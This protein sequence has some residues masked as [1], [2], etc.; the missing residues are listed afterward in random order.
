MNKLIKTM[1]V[2]SA[3]LASGSALA[4]EE[5][6]TYW[7]DT[8]ESG[9]SKNAWTTPSLWV[10][11]E[12]KSPEKVFD[13]T[14]DYVVGIQ[15]TSQKAAYLRWRNNNDARNFAG[16]S[17]TI[18]DGGGLRLLAAGGSATDPVT[19]GSGG[20][21][22]DKGTLY[23]FSNGGTLYFGGLVTV[24]SG[25]AT[26]QAN[27]DSS[28]PAPTAYFYS[29]FAGEEDATIKFITSKTNYQVFVSGDFQNFKGKVQVTSNT[30]GSGV[31]YGTRL[32]MRSD[33]PGSLE[34]LVGSTLIGAAPGETI[35]VKNLSFANGSVFEIPFADDGSSSGAVTVT[36]DLKL[37]A[38]PQPLV[39]TGLVADKLVKTPICR[40]FFT[41]PLA[42]KLSL[43][44]FAITGIPEG[45]AETP[46]LEL[47]TNETAQTVSLVLKTD[48]LISQTVADKH[49]TY[50]PDTSA[51]GNPDSWDAPLSSA[52][53]YYSNLQLCSAYDSTRSET[54]DG[55]SLT[56]EGNTFIVGLRDFRIDDL[57]IVDA[58]SLVPANRPIG[59]SSSVIVHYGISG[60]ITVPEG[61]TLTLLPWCG[62][63][64]EFWINSEICGSGDILFPGRTGTD[65][66]T[67]L[68]ILAGPNTN[69]FGGIKVRQQATRTYPDASRHQ[70]FRFF[71]PRNLGG[72]LAELN[73][74][75][76]EIG[77]YTQVT[78]TNSV[79][80]TR[81]ANRGLFVN[82][83]EAS[84]DCS[85]DVV[86]TSEWPLAVND[87]FIKSGAGRFV[88]GNEAVTF[89]AD[90]TAVEPVGDPT[91][92]MFRITGGDVKIASVDAVNGLDV[93]IADAGARIVL[94]L[95]AQTGDF[96]AYGVRNVK[97]ATPFARTADVTEPVPFV[98]ESAEAPTEACTRAVFTVKSEVY[99]ATAA[100]FKFT[101]GA[102]FKG[103]T[104]KRS[105]RDN[106]DGTTTMVA[107]IDRTGALLILR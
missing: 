9:G 38:K 11:A 104:I 17:L 78:L 48:G 100:C 91:N 105:P 10:D 29:T 71:E 72:D 33:I 65:S 50:R 98:F 49:S 4:E 43:D 63:K 60:K 61:A 85:K 75:A 39:L 96:A 26:I 67:G 77:G 52:A 54:F 74:K 53:R 32:T 103:W 101:K 8:N 92:H 88:M 12:G 66:V 94:D 64:L 3:L 23:T 106:G 82:D 95:T 21:I 19:F 57:R 18:R 5:R 1:G 93:V 36:G 7:L 73:R 84:I 2:F 68:G 46:R 37:E 87:T 13:S 107:E 59:I 44:D 41:V 62:T 16:H 70:Y 51:F 22:V 24:A 20:L 102:A 76:L 81:T 83:G 34:A 55:R 14:C 86:F 45:C 42:Q 79:T 28:K 89:G 25:G 80:L 6:P 97:T 27:S 69:F 15:P 35:T 99:E 56:L 40:T 90:A 58:A 31:R 47:V 30:D